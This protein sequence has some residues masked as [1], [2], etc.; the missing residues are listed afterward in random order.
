MQPARHLGAAPD[1]STDAEF[2][3]Q[4]PRRQHHAWFE[5][6]LDLDLRQRRTAVGN[7]IAGVQHPIDALDEALEPVAVDLVG[8]AEIVHHPG[9]SALGCGVPG[10]LGEGVIADRRAVSIASFGDSQIHAQRISPTRLLFNA[11]ITDSCV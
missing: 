6:P 3:P 1:R 4:L 10:I 2:L 5:H 8:A 11:L 7:R 9:L